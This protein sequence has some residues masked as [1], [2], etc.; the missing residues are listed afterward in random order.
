[1]TTRKWISI[2]AA[3]RE[4]DSSQTRIRRLLAGGQ[5]PILRIPGTQ[6]RVDVEALNKILTAHTAPY[7]SPRTAA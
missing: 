7:S 3:A 5:V 6:P 2:P 1:M 4:L